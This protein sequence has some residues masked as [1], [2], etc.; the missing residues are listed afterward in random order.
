VP[1]YDSRKK[2]I[3]YKTAFIFTGVVLV[4]LT[5][6][7][8]AGTNIL[9]TQGF[10]VSEVETKTMLLEKENQILSVKIEEATTLGCLQ[11][12]AEDRGFIRSKS[13]VFVPATSTFASR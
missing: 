11:K 4:G 7:N 1:N 2:L 9:S 10:A 13:I 6:I 8:L 5:V 12:L 3:N